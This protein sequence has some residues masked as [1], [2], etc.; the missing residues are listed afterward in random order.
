VFASYAQG[1]SGPLAFGGR[2]DEVGQAFGRARAATGFSLDLRGLITALPPLKVI[3][4]I[5]APYGNDASLLNI[6]NS[7]RLSGDKVIQELPGHDAHIQ[8]L[9][10][11]RKLVKQS[12]VWQVVPV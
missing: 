3:K 5:L 2:Y 9:G 10:C 7:L 8:E 4:G 6:I 1:C 12:G 11:D